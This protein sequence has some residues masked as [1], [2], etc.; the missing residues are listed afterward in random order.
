MNIYIRDQGVYLKKKGE[1]IAVIREEETLQE[2]LVKNIDNVILIGNVQLSTQVISML[3]QHGIDISYMTRNGR[4]IGS[5]HSGSSKNIFLKIAQYDR[6]KNPEFR[7]LMAKNIVKAKT[8]NQINIIRRHNWGHEDE[9][10]KGDVE[11]IISN[12]ENIDFKTT[13]NSLMGIEGV[14]SS[15]YFS[16]IAKIIKGFEFT[17]RQRPAL[18]PVNALL[19][20]G[21]TFLTNEIASLLFLNVI[22]KKMS[23]KTL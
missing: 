6:Y 17:K 5:T 9:S 11:K 20:L 1:R 14:C 18:E 13:I 7:L 22:L 23:I 3:M 2:I 12:L 4:F 10:W 21:Y 16:N 8:K 19:N 15:I